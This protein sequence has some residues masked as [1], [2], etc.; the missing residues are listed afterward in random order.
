MMAMAAAE[1]ERTAKALA[2]VAPMTAQPPTQ[3]VVATPTAA[4]AAM[5]VAPVDATTAQAAVAL[6]WAEPVW[7]ALLWPVSMTRTASSGMRGRRNHHR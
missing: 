3:E 6:L 4:P 1:E 2:A 7:L 5:Q